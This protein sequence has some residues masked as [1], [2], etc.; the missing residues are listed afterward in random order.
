M[1]L[2][3]TGLDEPM[4]SNVEM[5]QP[6]D[7]QA[8]MSLARVFEHRASAPTSTSPHSAMRHI[9]PVSSGELAHRTF[10]GI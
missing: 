1:N 6:V 5:Q 9:S 4:C 3:T 7:L 10:N 8:A 2:F